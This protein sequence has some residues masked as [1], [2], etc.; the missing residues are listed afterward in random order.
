MS[1]TTERMDMLTEF[2]N[3]DEKRAKNVLS[4]EPSIAVK[5]INEYGND[6]TEAELQAYGVALN[7]TIQQ[8]GDADLEGVAGGVSGNMDDFMS[9]D[10]VLG[11]V[12]GPAL[13]TVVY[14]VMPI[15]AI[16]RPGT[17][18]AWLTH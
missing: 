16:L 12:G 6:F 18:N 11:L 2:L 17:V 13:L 15:H 10:S 8:L 9:K 5:Q 3:A 1:I 4:L 7:E 14:G